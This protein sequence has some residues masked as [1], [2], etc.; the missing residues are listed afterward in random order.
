[1]KKQESNWLRIW[2]MGG[3]QPSVLARSKTCSPCFS[4]RGRFIWGTDDG[5]KAKLCSNSL[6][7]EFS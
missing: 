5:M 1:L 2:R 6:I 4:K 3:K 7:Q